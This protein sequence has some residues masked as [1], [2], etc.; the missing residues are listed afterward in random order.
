MVQVIKYCLHLVQHRGGLFFD[1][2]G[3]PVDFR[4]TRDDGTTYTTPTWFPVLQQI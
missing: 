3:D 4:G 1:A 2:A